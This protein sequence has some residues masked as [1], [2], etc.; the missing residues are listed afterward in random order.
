MSD[1][2][3]E[4]TPCSSCYRNGCSCVYV[5]G[6]CYSTDKPVYSPS[7]KIL[8]DENRRLKEENLKLIEYK[9]MYEEL[10]K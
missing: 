6:E 8:L 7:L 5:D 2:K 9:F 1:V 10:C 3:T 4:T